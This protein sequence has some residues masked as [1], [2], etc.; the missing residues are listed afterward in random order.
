VAHVFFQFGTPT[1]IGDASEA[2]S[3]SAATTGNLM[4]YDP[5]ADQ[6]IFNWDI[7]GAAIGNGTYTIWID[8]GEGECGTAHNVVV[9]IQKVG[10]GIR[11]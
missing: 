5:I 11:K 10:K 6:Y 4:R 3:T 9:S 2:V 7:T 8:L 1:V